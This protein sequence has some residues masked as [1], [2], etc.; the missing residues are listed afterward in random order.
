MHQVGVRERPFIIPASLAEVL[1]IRRAAVTGVIAD[2]SW[3][4]LKLVDREFHG[5]VI[6]CCQR[7]V[8][9][10]MVGLWISDIVEAYANLT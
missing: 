3:R 8:L 5:G 4:I 10:L 1:V 9:E 2:E 7:K 6:V